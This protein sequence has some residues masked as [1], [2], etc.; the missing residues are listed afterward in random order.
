MDYKLTS[1]SGLE[2]V[3]AQSHKLNHESS[4]L[5]SATNNIPIVYLFL[6]ILG[7]SITVITQDFGP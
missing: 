6:I 1:R 4:N 7:F 5:S 3:P 2:M